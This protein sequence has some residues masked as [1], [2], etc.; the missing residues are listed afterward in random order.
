MRT[1]RIAS[2]LWLNLVFGLNI[3]QTSINFLK[4]FFFNQLSKEGIFL[5][6]FVFGPGRGGGGEECS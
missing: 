1:P 5:F 3:F 4:F 2:M 6:F